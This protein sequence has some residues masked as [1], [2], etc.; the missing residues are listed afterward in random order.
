M[1]EAMAFQ[2]L[3]VYVVAKELAVLVHRAKISDAELRDQAGAGFDVGVPSALGGASER[4]RRNAS[5]VHRVFS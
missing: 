5:E 2:N 4:R 3:D 1:K